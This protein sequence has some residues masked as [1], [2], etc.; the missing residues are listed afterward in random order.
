M[1][2]PPLDSLVLDRLRQLSVDGG[3]DVL[4]EVLRIF[5]ED[6]PA[7]LSRLEAACAAGDL[8]ALERAA[9]SIKGSAG[10]IGARHLQSLCRDAEAAARAADLAATR[11]AVDQVDAE[12]ARV[13]DAIERLLKDSG[14][15][16]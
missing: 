9:H 15:R 3:P 14:P 13:S 16:G 4:A 12:V 6:V 2:E 7:R 10:N 11:A 8:A 5:R 1:N